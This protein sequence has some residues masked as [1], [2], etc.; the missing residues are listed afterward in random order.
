M[1]KQE[2]FALLHRENMWHEITEHEAVIT[3]EDLAKVPLPYPEADAKNLFVRDDKKRSYYLITNAMIA[4]VLEYGKH[5]QPPRPWLKRTKAQA[6][7]VF[8]QAAQ[9]KFEEEIDKL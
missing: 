9:Q 7:D 3:M 6:K 1:N 8:L 4:N 5:G 2:V